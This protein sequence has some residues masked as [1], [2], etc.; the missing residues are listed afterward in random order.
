M[1]DTRN[2]FVGV[3]VAPFVSQ[4]CAAHVPAAHSKID[5]AAKHHSAMQTTLQNENAT[6]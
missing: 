5:V 3:L 1:S 6:L 2:P 4:R